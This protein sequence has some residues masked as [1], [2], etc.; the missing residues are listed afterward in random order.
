MTRWLPWLVLAAC[1]TPGAVAV[2]GDERSPAAPPPPID[3]PAPR[4]PVAALSLAPEDLI[5]A[6]PIGGATMAAPA[7]GGYVV[8][9]DSTGGVRLWSALDGTREPVVVRTRGAKQIATTR[10]GEAISIAVVDTLGQLELVRVT[11]E[12]RAIERLA[13]ETTRP[14]IELVATSRGFVVLR[15][16]QQ[17]ALFDPRGGRRG[18]LEPAPGERIAKLVAS[19]DHVLAVMT[20]RGAKRMARWIDDLA[21]GARSAR[22]EC[23]EDGSVFLSPD[24][25]ELLATAGG[26]ADVVRV[27]LA[28]G[29]VAAIG[30]DA[31]TNRRFD[32][33]LGYLGARRVRYLRD[34]GVFEWNDGEVRPL[35]TELG[36]TWLPT[37]RGAIGGGGA[38]YVIVETRGAAKYLGYRADRLVDL[39][40]AKAGGW[41]A[42]DG[43]SLVHLDARLRSDRTFTTPFPEPENWLQPITLID[44][45]HVVIEDDQKRF[46]YQLGQEAGELIESTGWG[47]GFERSTNLA[48]IPGTQ[49]ALHWNPS[50]H[51]FDPD[52]VTLSDE[53]YGPV[54]L[55]DPRAHA[56]MIAAQINE[57]QEATTLVPGKEQITRREV[58]ALGPHERHR[59]VHSY[60]P[61][62][63][64][65]SGRSGPNLEPLL[66]EAVQWAES[67]DGTLI[68]ELAGGRITLH[69]RAGN[70]RWV[71]TAD[72]ARGL[73]WNDADELVAF[74]AGAA[75]V[76]LETGAYRLRQCGW[77]FGLWDKPPATSGVAEI[78][79]AP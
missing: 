32:A 31:D 64:L 65:F 44:E 7:D 13:I 9:A 24:G 3:A 70:V 78:C 11:T 43:A 33:A 35:A 27:D 41:V 17:L 22:F 23:D 60:V 45:R 74:G 6:S 30:N 40:P 4:Y 48:L 49:Q 58:F 2:A 68:A 59:D 38:H 34:G 28:T 79:V 53:P 57:V 36:V 75:L 10:D 55:Y 61:F 63:D 56:G 69:D 21:W 42:T 14:V 15:D 37:E 25:R 46:L 73:A 1:G 62:D 47:L 66:P 16:D 19:G 26:K 12:G 20:A 8:M 77:R 71:R 72:G 67:A 76:D 39:V 51:A 5:T 18:E 54:R 29:K 50:K 52:P